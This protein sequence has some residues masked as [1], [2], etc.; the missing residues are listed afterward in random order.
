MQVMGNSLLNF[1]KYTHITTMQI[2]KQ[3][4]ASSPS[5][6]PKLSQRNQSSNFKQQR[7]L[8]PIFLV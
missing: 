7:L 5:P 2:K 1:H 3:N 4:I 6:S 8:W